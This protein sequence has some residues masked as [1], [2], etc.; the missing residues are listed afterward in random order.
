[1]HQAGPMCCSLLFF[2]DTPYI[3]KGIVAMTLPLDEPMLLW[4]LLS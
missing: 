4:M 2:W 3:R 1:M